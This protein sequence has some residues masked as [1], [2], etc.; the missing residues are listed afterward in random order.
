MFKNLE[1]QVE[2]HS[3]FN[4]GI[5]FN[6]LLFILTAKQMEL[7]REMLR[8]GLTSVTWHPSSKNIQFLLQNGLVFKPGELFKDINSPSV[9]QEV[10]TETLTHRTALSWHWRCDQAH[11]GDHCHLS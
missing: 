11:L 3:Q 8:V 6:V 10:K 4:P 5:V 1:A 2:R 7:M 9:V